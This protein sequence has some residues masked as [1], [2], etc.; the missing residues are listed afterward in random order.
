MCVIGLE[1]RFHRTMPVVEDGHTYLSADTGD[2]TE[3]DSHQ[4]A[5]RLEGPSVTIYEH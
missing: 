3:S 2:E 1:Y 4:V 5:D